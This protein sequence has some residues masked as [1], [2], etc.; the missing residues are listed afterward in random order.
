MGSFFT[1]RPWL[2]RV[3]NPIDENPPAFGSTREFSTDLG[4][5]KGKW[6]A[7]TDF[8]TARYK[9]EVA[10]FVLNSSTESLEFVDGERFVWSNGRQVV[11]GNW[12]NNGSGIGFDPASVDGVPAKTALDRLAGQRALPMRSPEY[13][14]T[15][16]AEGGAIEQV[17][18]LGPM[19]LM[20]DQKRLFC[21]GN[22]DQSGQ[23]FLGT[24]VW[25]RVKR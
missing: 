25:D 3:R 5:L 10:Q 15:W 23:T 1:I 16:M 2:F 12:N 21:S 9:D 8:S 4:F 24:T 13:N 18:K 17:R 14:R 6:V 20:P 11:T 7:H 19:K 22:I